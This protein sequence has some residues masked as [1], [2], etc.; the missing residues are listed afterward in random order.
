MSPSATVPTTA[1]STGSQSPLDVSTQTTKPN[2]KGY[3]HVTWYVGN[4]KQAASYFITRFGFRH[5]AYA[6]LETGSRNVTSHVVSNGGATFV[7]SA[8][9]RQVDAVEKDTPPAEKRML[10]DIHTHQSQH[11]DAVKDVAFEVDDARAIYHRAIE[12][13]ATSVQE[14]LTLKD[15]FG[16]VTT[17]II[18]T[19]GDTTHTLVEK[20]NYRGAFLPGYQSFEHDDPIQKYLPAVSFEVI[21]HCVGNQGWG[22]LQAVCDYYENALSFHRFW[23]ADDSLLSQSYS[24][25]SSIVMASPAPLS[26]IKMPINEPAPGLRKSQIEEFVTFNAGPGVQHIA[27]RCADIIATVHHLRERGVEFIDV[28]ATYYQVLRKRLFGTVTTAAGG[29]EKKRDWQLKEDLAEIERLRILVDFDE[30]GYLLQI[31]T[32]PVLDRPTVFM[33]VIQRENFEGFGAGNFKGLFE[34]LEL[35]QGRRGNL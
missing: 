1:T 7:L 5:I 10:A 31:F 20:T 24:A 32:K 8:P 14:P 2:F 29:D 15:D 6:G 17:A 12:R 3:H 34:A 9:L 21:D 26:A 22:G 27:F 16:E 33:E 25:M 28:P 11:G 19:Y 30:G 18:K 4:A 13:G 23:T 35:E